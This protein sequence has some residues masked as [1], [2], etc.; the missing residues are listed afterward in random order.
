MK[1]ALSWPKGKKKE[2]G[3]ESWDSQEFPRTWKR[4]SALVEERRGGEE[5]R[6]EKRRGEERSSRIEWGRAPPGGEPPGYHG[7]MHTHGTL[8]HPGYYANRQLIRPLGTTQEYP[9]GQWS[10]LMGPMCPYGV[11]FAPKTIPEILLIV[12]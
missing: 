3:E 9:N 6:G 11:Y 10:L 8:Q 12:G 4:P 5:R 7:K 2:R 1:V